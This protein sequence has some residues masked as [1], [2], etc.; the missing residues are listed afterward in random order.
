MERE[1]R[2]AK[3]KGPTG[4]GHRDEDTGD[5]GHRKRIGGG[6]D[7]YRPKNKKLDRPSNADRESTLYTA[8]MADREREIP[9][10]RLSYRPSPTK[11]IRPTWHLPR[12]SWKASWAWPKFLLTRVSKDG[13]M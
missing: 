9:L 13:H 4:R 5:I 3:G 8:R 2:A 6:V 1:E 12:S 11:L 7:K 10:C